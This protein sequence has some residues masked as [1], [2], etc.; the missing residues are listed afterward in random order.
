[1]MDQTPVFDIKP[2]IPAWD[3]HPNE[4]AGFTETSGK[5][6]LEVR[7]HEALLTVLPK[8]KRAPL[9][10]ALAQDPRPSYQEDPER[11]YGISFA[12]FNVQF[13][14]AAA[15]L[16]VTAVTPILS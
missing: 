12:G 7:C 2:Y 16:T 11:I 9:L 13:K 8:E 1:M 10:A 5:R 14:I 15:T 3:A 4:R 6:L